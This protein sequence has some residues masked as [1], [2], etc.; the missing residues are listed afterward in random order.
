[1]QQFV[2]WLTTQPGRNGRLRDRSIANAITPLRRALDAA[3]A[4][5]L[6]DVNPFNAAVLPR[7]AV[8]V[9]RGR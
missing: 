7:A 4:A 3:V 5:G 1:V 2:D 8:P 9:V 6:L